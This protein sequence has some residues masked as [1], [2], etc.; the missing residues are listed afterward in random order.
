MTARQRVPGGSPAPRMETPSR[1]S[2]IARLAICSDLVARRARISRR[3]WPYCVRNQAFV[4]RSGSKAL[5]IDRDKSKPDL[6]ELAIKSLAHCGLEHPRDFALLQ[7]EPRDLAMVSHAR[8]RKAHRMKQLL[9]LRHAPQ[10]LGRYLGA[11]RKTRRQA[12]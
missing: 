3:R 9:P 8:N 4:E 5:Q 12:R 10:P 1:G 11:V 2:A 6:F 7:L